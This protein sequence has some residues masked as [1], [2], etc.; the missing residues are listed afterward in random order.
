MNN[1]SPIPVALNICASYLPAQIE[2]ALG[3]CLDKACSAP[4]P[5]TRVL[6]KPNLLLANKLACTNPNVI[7]AVCKWLLD[8]GAKPIVSD[9]PGFGTVKRIASFIGLEELLKRLGIPLREMSDPVS[10]LLEL[11]SHKKA[12]MKISRL[13]MEADLI[14][15]VAKLKAH[16]QMRMSLCVKNCFGCVPGTRKALVHGLHAATHEEFADWLTAIWRSLPK[17]TAV[18]DGIECMHVTGPAKGEPFNLNLVAA[19]ESGQLLD[20]TL[21]KILNIPIEIV[22]LTYFIARSVAPEKVSPQYVLRK[23]D[24]FNGAGFI[25]P[26]KLKPASFNFYRIL[27]SSV[28]RFLAAHKKTS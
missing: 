2:R 16:S 20:M 3:D 10:V 22:P 18:C 4:S 28:R 19:C 23:P 26:E 1:F 13:A 21:L 24:E 9:S 7:V 11:N 25:Y 6:V 27:I 17:V 14:F 15:S 12:S 8:N 5:G